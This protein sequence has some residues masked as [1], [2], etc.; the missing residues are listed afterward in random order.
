MSIYTPTEVSSDASQST[1][2]PTDRE[3][4]VADTGAGLLI[5]ADCDGVGRELVAFAD[6]DDWDAIRGAL[7]KR[8]LDVGATY[9]LPVVNADDVPRMVAEV[10]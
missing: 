1:D 5:F 7:Q 4:T 8:G 9:H 6:I 10:A 3:L 2:L